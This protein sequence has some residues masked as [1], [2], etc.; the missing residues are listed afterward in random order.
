MEMAN[1]CKHIAFLIENEYVRLVTLQSIVTNF[2]VND[3]L[4]LDQFTKNLTERGV[5]SHIA[6]NIPKSPLLE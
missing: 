6:G 5:D 4:E 1:L 2:V 3:E